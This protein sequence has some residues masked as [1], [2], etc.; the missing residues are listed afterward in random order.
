MDEYENYFQ[1]KISLRPEEM[2]VGLNY[3]TDKRTVTTKLRN[4]NTESVDWYKF[5]IPIEEYDKIVII[6]LPVGSAWKICVLSPTTRT[7]T[8]C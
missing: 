5:R 2:Q 4:G 1:Y 6:C 8:G 7:L 3:I